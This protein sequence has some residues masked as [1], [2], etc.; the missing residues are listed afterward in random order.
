[1]NE[2]NAALD[3]GEAVGPLAI[4]A[5]DKIAG[6]LGVTSRVVAM[7]VEG[8]DAGAVSE[9]NLAEIPPNDPSEELHRTWALE[10]AVRRKQVKSARNY[11]EADRIRDLLR[12]AGW[13]VRDARDGSVDVIRTQRAS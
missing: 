11:P 2:G 4:A 10:W 8:S 5:W 12:A 13:E 7:R 3:A 6:V 9:G 1:M